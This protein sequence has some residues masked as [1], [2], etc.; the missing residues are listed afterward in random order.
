M[1]KYKIITWER[2]GDCG[3]NKWYNINFGK[4]TDNVKY[5]CVKCNNT[6]EA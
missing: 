1:K 3:S 4:D 2:C 5:V 6:F